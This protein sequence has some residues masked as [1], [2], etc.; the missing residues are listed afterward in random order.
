MFRPSLMQSETAVNIRSSVNLTR[1]GAG[2]A[3]SVV[4]SG[5][6]KLLISLMPISS[7]F[8][9]LKTRVSC[10]IFQISL[11]TIPGSGTKI[12]ASAVLL[13][14]PDQRSVVQSFQGI[15]WQVLRSILLISAGQTALSLPSGPLWRSPLQQAQKN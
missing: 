14:P 5:C 8:R 2:T 9:R 3:M 13:P 4:W 12:T 15:L 10:M 11:L 7:F 6:V 1:T